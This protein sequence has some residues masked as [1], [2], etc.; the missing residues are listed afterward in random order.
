MSKRKISV[1][2]VTSI[3]LNVFL[4]GIVASCYMVK[5]NRG[6]RPPPRHGG[7]AVQFE[8][9]KEFLSDD[10]KSIVDEVLSQ[11]GTNMRG[12]MHEIGGLQ[13]EAHDVLTAD[14][15]EPERL[16]K[17]H[18]KMHSN[19]VGVKEQLSQTIY[20]IASKLSDED[21]IKFFEKALPDRPHHPPPPRR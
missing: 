18:D 8:R 12:N 15:F 19:S 20:D 16:N 6:D 2:L 5:P 1:I 21:R 9:A 11:Q 3:L 10:G 13:R 7:P 4:I 14:D 17:I